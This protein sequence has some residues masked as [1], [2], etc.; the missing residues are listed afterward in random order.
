VSRLNP[1]QIAVKLLPLENGQTV[2]VLDASDEQF[3]AFRLVVGIPVKEGEE[4]VK[5]SWDNRC[6]AI[7]HALKYGL[8]LPFV[9]QITSGNREE[10]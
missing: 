4:G 2:S 9:E 5:W 10:Q 7:N 1:R 6:R 8:K 3:E